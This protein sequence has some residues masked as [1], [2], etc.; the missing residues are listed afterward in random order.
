M[1]YNRMGKVILMIAM[2]FMVFVNSEVAYASSLIV[3]GE[4]PDLEEEAQAKDVY[5]SL[6][7]VTDAYK[8]Y[9]VTVKNPGMLRIKFTGLNGNV[10][11]ALFDS[12]KIMLSSETTVKAAKPQATYYVGKTGTYFFRLK[13]AAGKTA[14]AKYMF[15]KR[16]KLGGTTFAKADILKKGV[17]KSSIFGFEGS[18]SQKQ[19]FKIKITNEELVRVKITKGNSCSDEDTVY[20]RIYK[21]NDKKNRVTWGWIYE[22]QGKAT[23]YIRNS[24]NHK[25]IPG[26]YYIVLSKAFKTS[27]FDYSL[28][29]LK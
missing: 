24:K 7:K 28:T 17:K 27:G 12:Q 14:I 2:S 19:Y 9:K 26:T 3:E 15:S 25:T 11:A 5:Y 29:W 13:C 22:G 8:F 6:G 4:Q 20:I 18:T 10:K 21:S 23:L 1:K 16:I